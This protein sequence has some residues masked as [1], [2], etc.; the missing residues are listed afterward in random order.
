MQW[1]SASQ[2]KAFRKCE[3]AALAEV[4]GEYVRPTTT[5]L[6]VGSY[7]D[8]KL[9]G[10]EAFEAF[11][12][13]HPEIFKKDGTLKADY[14]QAEEIYQRIQSDR[15]MSL[16]LSGRKQVIVTGT[17]AKVPFRG[18]LDSLLDVET[19]RTIMEEFP[20]TVNVLGGPF[21][22]GAIVDGKVMRDFQPVWSDTEWRKVHWAQAWD[23][24]IQGAIYQHLVKGH[25]PFI[26]AAATKEDGADLDALHIPQ[27]ELDAA[28]QIVKT[29]APRYQAIKKGK[30][31]PIGCGQ[32]EWCRRNKV[33]TTIRNFKEV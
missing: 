31:E 18:K 9:E 2:F 33:L 13:E 20:N 29:D 22:T 5:A 1:M 21:C 24:P 14:I 17:I 28:L 25:K 30:I 7:V 23:Y 11:Q 10:P 15:L 26:L 8:S 3:A 4:R 32:C 16:L 6:L 19:C 27:N 12:V